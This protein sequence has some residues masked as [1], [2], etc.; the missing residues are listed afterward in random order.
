MDPG[1]PLESGGASGAAPVGTDRVVR[2]DAGEWGWTWAADADGR[3]HQVGL[4]PEGARA[5]VEVDPVWYPDAHP[6][7]G[8]ADP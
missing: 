2:V 1:E 5:P 6:T 8:G 4:G 3:L 7:W